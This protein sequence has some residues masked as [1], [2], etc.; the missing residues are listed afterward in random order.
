MCMAVKTSFIWA[1]LL[2][3]DVDLCVT[4]F[5]DIM[6]MKMSEK[7]KPNQTHQA[8]LSLRLWN[9]IHLDYMAE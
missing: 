4:M 2:E 5:T 6:E 1:I 9:K 8:Q 7:V 3:H